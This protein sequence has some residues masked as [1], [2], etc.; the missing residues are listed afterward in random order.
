MAVSSTETKNPSLNPGS[1]W[2]EL[3]ISQ[4]AVAYMPY[5][6]FH[7]SVFE[8]IGTLKHGEIDDKKYFC[9]PIV[10]LCPETVKSRFNA[11]SQ[12]H[13]VHLEIELWNR[14]VESMVAQHMKKE[15][16]KSVDESKI[17]VI[18]FEE[19]ILCCT[20]ATPM[21]ELTNTWMPYQ[22]HN[23]V[24]FYLNCASKEKAE[25]VEKVCHDVIIHHIFAFN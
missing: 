4:R 20:I 23:K 11:V 9:S 7:V 12:C 17:S 21:F 10:T 8:G 6:D 16:G 24:K 22:L 5:R 19:V 15:T 1:T 18:P 3:Q 14:E 13:Q 25:Q 2:G